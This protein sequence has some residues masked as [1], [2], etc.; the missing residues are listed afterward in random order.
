MR[1]PRVPA[2]RPH[3][4][5]E[6]QRVMQP[7]L[8]AEP[9]RRL[10]ARD[11]LARHP[12][13]RQLLR[14]R[15]VAHVVDDQ[16]VADIAFHLGRDVGVALVH[17]E[18]MHADAAGLLVRDLLRL[19]RIGDVVDLEAAHGVAALRFRFD[20][21]DVLRLDA[22]PGRDLRMGRRAALGG[23]QFLHHPRQLVGA[24]A[25]RGRVAL[26]IDDHDVADHARL[27]AV[28]RAVVERDGRD[29]AR[30]R[31]IGNVDDR[32]AEVVL[33]RDVPDIGM[34]AGDAHLSRAG[35]VDVSEP[36]DV[37]GHGWFCSLDDVHVLGPFLYARSCPALCRASTS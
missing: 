32:G 23:G 34:R 28:R 30:V 27:V 31:R 14:L 5:A 29:H 3:L 16:D 35:Q 26:M 1:K 7:V 10:A 25:D 13:A 2:A 12:P 37:A 20:L 36:A 22:E 18:A 33:V 21:G 6:A 17:I 11:V 24:A 4:V 15:R 9:G 8:A 19:R